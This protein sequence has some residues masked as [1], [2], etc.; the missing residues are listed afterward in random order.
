MRARAASERANARTYAHTSVH[1]YAHVRSLVRSH[2]HSSVHSFALRSSPRPLA[3]RTSYVHR[4]SWS[5]KSIVYEVLKKAKKSSTKLLAPTDPILGLENLLKTSFAQK[6]LPSV[7]FAHACESWTGNFAIHGCLHMWIW[8][9][10]FT[11]HKVKESWRRVQFALSKKQSGHDR[12]F[13]LDVPY[14]ESRVSDGASSSLSRVID[15][16]FLDTTLDPVFI[17]LEGKKLFL[18]RMADVSKSP[19]YSC[20]HKKQNIF[21]RF[22]RKN[23]RFSYFPLSHS[24]C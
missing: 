8:V 17:P 4:V 14:E 21:V 6:G 2:V 1:L 7:S 11:E 23:T 5:F 9:V 16:I 20:R 3:T 13:L 12:P 19:Q 18:L 10:K 15:Q 22:F 24:K